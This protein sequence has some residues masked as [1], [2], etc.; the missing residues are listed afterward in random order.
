VLWLKYL[1]KR[2]ILFHADISVIV[3]YANNLHQKIRS[4]LYATKAFDEPYSRYKS[5]IAW[6]HTF[7]CN[8][9]NVC[10]LKSICQNA[11][12]HSLKGQCHEIFEPRF[13]RQ[14][15]TP[16]PLINTLKYFRFLFRIRRSITELV[17]VQRYAA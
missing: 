7:Q 5:W 15:I 12:S 6:F 3:F 2:K 14:S 8:D 13:F 17:F 9:D 11:K 16:R 4:S 10:H 1:Q